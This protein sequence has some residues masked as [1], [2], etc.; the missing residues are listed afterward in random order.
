[1]QT[2]KK[3]YASNSIFRVDFNDVKPF[4]NPAGRLPVDYFRYPQSM[5][6][7]LKT[8]NQLLIENLLLLTMF[9]QFSTG[10]RLFTYMATCMR[11]RYYAEPVV[12]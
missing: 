2:E 6:R 1:M 5:P 12:I 7:V 8:T 10:V 11:N 3:F 9:Q 4:L